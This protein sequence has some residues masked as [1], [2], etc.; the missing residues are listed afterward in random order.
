[1]KP[2]ELLRKIFNLNEDYIEAIAGKNS[3]EE[4]KQNIEKFINKVK[5]NRG[6]IISIGTAISSEVEK[7]Y[8][9]RYDG[10]KKGIYSTGYFEDY[11]FHTNLSHHFIIHYKCKKRIEEKDL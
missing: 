6:K 8:I 9:E 7:E 1:M 11:E 5:T 10:N 2:S 3:P 4:D